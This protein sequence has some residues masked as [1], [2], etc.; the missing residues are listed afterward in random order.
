[1][2]RIA[3]FAA[4]GAAVLAVRAELPV[5][6]RVVQDVA[7]YNSWPMIQAL[8]MRLVCTYSRGTAHSNAEH[9]RGAYA[10]FSDDEG[11]TWSDEVTVAQ[12]GGYGEVPIGKGL[13]GH[14]H[15]LFWIRAMGGA[16]NR[17]EL[18]RTRD[19]ATFE[20]IASLGA[21]ALDPFPQQIT[22]IFAVPGRG[23]MALWFAGPYSYQSGYVAESGH[24]WGYV[25]STDGGFTW[26]QT[27]VEANL[28]NADWP[29]EPSVA[30]LGDGRLLAIARTECG[31]CQFQ[32]VSSDSGFTWTRGRTNIGDVWI[33]TPSLV[34]D[35]R[36]DRVINYYFQRGSGVLRC[37]T[38]APSVVWDAPTAWP[39]S[40]VVGIGSMNSLETGNVNATV[41][42]ATHFVAYYSGAVPTTGVY[43]LPLTAPSPSR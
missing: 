32:M 19:G 10:R 14:G 13:D 39:A 43:V 16:N 4:A 9:G 26:R 17:H 36:T 41:V 7:G 12:D 8:G 25:L 38:V 40:T 34:Y 18:F 6:P 27:T 31:G 23:L 15:A 29:T 11:R 5:A 37:R 1:M 30:P 42:G 22:D 33:S 24:S 2:R 20:K 28:A 21:A 35:A 3:I